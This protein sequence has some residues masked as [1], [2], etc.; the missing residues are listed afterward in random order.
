MNIKFRL[1]TQK[2]CAIE[3]TYNP[4][5]VNLTKAIPSR[6]WDANNK[7]WTIQIADVNGA[8]RLYENAGHSV[9]MSP[10]LKIAV[11]KVTEKQ[12]AILEQ[13]KVKE[14]DYDV[15]AMRF[16]NT[17]LEHQYEAIE[18]A[19]KSNSLLLADDMGLGKTFVSINTACIRK[20]K[21]NVKKTLIVCGINSVKY[22][23][24]EEI[25]IHSYEEGTVFEGK[26]LSERLEMVQAWIKN[27]DTNYFGIINVESLQREEI[28][29]SLELGVKKG[30]IG[31]VVIDE[32]HKCKN[33]S[34]IRGK[35]IHKL[36]AEYKLA[37]TGT[38]IMNRAEELYN[39]LKWLGAEIKTFTQFKNFYCCFGGFMNN[40]VIGYKNL[41]VLRKTLSG[42]MLRRRKEDVLNLPDKIYKTEYLLMSKKSMK[43]YMEVRQDLIRKIDEI[44]LDNNPLSKLLRLRQITSG[45]L[46]D[47]SVKFDRLL[48]I[49]E[50]AKET[51]KKVIV[52]SQWKAV[53][54][55]VNTYLKEK[56]INTYIIDGTVKAE[57]RQALV[58]KYQN[59]KGFNVIT[60]TI[61]AMGTGLTLN[62]AE[63]VVFLDKAWT[64]SDNKQAEDRAYRIG[65][66]HNVNV[67]S[68][69]CKNTIDEYIENMLVEKQDLFNEVVEGKNTRPQSKERLL[70]LLLGV[71]K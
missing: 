39:I 28:V 61:G 23:W 65:T 14:L 49:L 48:E 34:S 46:S 12:Q 70:R 64:P 71:D 51:N 6:K 15:R 36:N 56:G 2:S 52:F 67:I 20:I 30:I 41:D 69:V 31:F 45:L 21:N 17:P 5:V 26:N 3:F 33:P 63:I 4:Q 62:T 27:E 35:A 54:D 18:R 9:S 24:Q 37:L 40:D 29:K 13:V 38:P 57:D 43:L 11:A 25:K 50:E 55:A 10:D 68:L 32:V 47:D 44:V 1:K 22:N 53:T 60:G 59:S 58:N 66:K 8:K 16:K 19:L 7:C 42:C